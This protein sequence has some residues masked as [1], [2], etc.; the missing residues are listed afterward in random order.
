MRI[1][2]DETPGLAFA[3]VLA[4]D[5]RPRDK[6]ALFGR[7][8]VDELAFLAHQRALERLVGEGDAAE[9]GD[10]FAEGQLAVDVHAGQHLIAVE[11]VHHL[12]GAGLELLGVGL[13]PPLREVAVSVVVAT[14][15]VEA[16]RDFVADDRPDAAVVD[17]V[18]QREVEERRPGNAGG[19]VLVFWPAGAKRL[20]PA[21]AAPP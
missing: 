12:L 5:L 1:N 3:R 13:R 8:T 17:G 9:V 14:L 10:V 20:Y 15:V 4:P 11:L 18:I 7:E 19:G 16:V 2:G 21:S 6:E